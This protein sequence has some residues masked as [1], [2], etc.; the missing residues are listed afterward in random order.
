MAI[1]DLSPGNSL[2]YDHVAPAD[3]GFTFVCFNALTGDRS[4]WTTGIGPALRDKGHGLLTYNLR[5]QADSP[6]T[7]DAVDEA[8]IVADALALLDHVRPARPVHVG[9]SIG[10]LFALKAHL[11]GAGAAGGAGAAEGLVLINTLR[12]AGPRLDW[13]ND[14]VARAA[15]VGGL[16]LLRDLF[17]PLL[18]NEEWQAQNRA[19]F[20]HDRSY[21]PLPAN[22]GALILLKSGATADWNVPYE[23]VDVPVLA[24]T[25]LQ[26]HVFLEPADVAALCTRLPDV[27]RIDMGDAGHMIP[28]ERPE[29]LAQAILD[30]AD[31]L[32]AD[33]TRA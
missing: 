20:L 21:A 5:G 3:G 26:D 18:F 14:A 27:E 23:T 16:E 33:D 25:G 2:A 9:L 22:D 8:A 11:S 6:F 24:V 30:F 4:M 29:A 7:F 19:N 1:F 31:R 17:A 13:L 15:E 32:R 28:A 10:G 12:R